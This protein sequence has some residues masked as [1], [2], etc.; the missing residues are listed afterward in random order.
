MIDTATRKE[1]KKELISGILTQKKIASCYDV[2]LSFVES[3]KRKMNSSLPPEE[4]EYVVLKIEK[5][6]LED[7]L[8][9]LEEFRINH[10]LPEPEH[11]LLEYYQSKINE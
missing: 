8:R 9:V 4:R 1:I 6:F 10:K 7:A 3:V 2:S 5:P 11:E